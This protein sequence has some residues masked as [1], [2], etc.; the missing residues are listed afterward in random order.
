VVAAIETTACV[1]KVPAGEKAGPEYRARKREAVTRTLPRRQ[2][3]PAIHRAHLIFRQVNTLALVQAGFCGKREL[4]GHERNAGASAAG[5]TG[6]KKM[7]TVSEKIDGRHA[8]PS[9]SVPTHLRL[10]TRRFS[11]VLKARNN[12][13]KEQTWFW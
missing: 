4:T 2:P 3:R 8:K 13:G 1:N 12:N 5:Q 7:L 11:D 10:L 6:L 9:A